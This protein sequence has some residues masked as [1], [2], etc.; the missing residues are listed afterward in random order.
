VVRPKEGPFLLG[1]VLLVA[2]RDQR[3]FQGMA[4][5]RWPF[6]FSAVLKACPFGQRQ[7]AG[8]NAGDGMTRHEILHEEIG[9][10]G[11]RLLGLVAFPQTVR[12][13]LFFCSAV[14]VPC[15]RSVSLCTAT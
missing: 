10:A 15:I 7:V 5:G 11:C 1:V 8:G 2:D 9:Q 12:F 3:G 14:R 13:F 4:H 6:H